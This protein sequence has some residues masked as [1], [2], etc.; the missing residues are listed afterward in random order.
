MK[1]KI[2]LEYDGTRYSGWQMQKN[3]KSIQGRSLKLPESSSAPMRTS[4]GQAARTRASTPSPRSPTWKLRRGWIR[5][6]VMFALNDNLPSN[7]NILSVDFADA[8][9]HARHNAKSRSYI[10]IISKRRTAFAKKYVWWVRD[11]LNVKKME[12]ACAVFRGFHDFA[13][14]ADKRIDK[15]SSTTVQVDAVELHEL[16]DL[17]I[18]RIAASH[19]LWRMA[20]RMVGI[21]VEVGRGSLSRG[22]VEALLKRPLRTARALY[23]APVRPVPGAGPVRGRQ[24]EPQTPQVPAAA[25]QV[26]IALKPVEMMQV[27]LS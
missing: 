16:G 10:Y 5:H 1:Y 12:A 7:I 18:F 4:R 26:G 25:E 22:D 11:P 6:K 20:R 2:I 23:S 24:T 21:L 27:P 14:F 17:I 15:G 19:F 9:F 8:R 13:A 3:A